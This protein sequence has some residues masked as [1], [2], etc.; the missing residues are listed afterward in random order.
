MIIVKIKKLDM[1]LIKLNYLPAMMKMIEQMGLM[2]NNY[3]IKL[4]L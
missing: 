3:F 1:F 4:K 2:M